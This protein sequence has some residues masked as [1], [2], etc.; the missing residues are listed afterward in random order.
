[1]PFFGGLEVFAHPLWFLFSIDDMSKTEVYLL[2][3]L[4]VF[5]LMLVVELSFRMRTR[6][7]W[8]TLNT[9][10]AD[11]ICFDLLK[12]LVLWAL[13]AFGYSALAP[14]HLHV[15]E[16]KEVF[17]GKKITYFKESGRFRALYDASVL[18]D[19]TVYSGQAFLNAV[20]RDCL[21][22]RASVD[23]RSL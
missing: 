18:F 10:E 8:R 13:V 20:E 23:D 3:L 6:T 2:Y 5:P 12:L 22:L 7:F 9:E 15:A 11:A 14:L 4:C 19:M 1:M 17:S 21:H 16:T